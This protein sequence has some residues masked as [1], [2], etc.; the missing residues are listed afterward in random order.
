M[1][2]SNPGGT[3]GGDAGDFQDII[4]GKWQQCILFYKTEQSLYT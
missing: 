4:E 1:V 3:G 2:E